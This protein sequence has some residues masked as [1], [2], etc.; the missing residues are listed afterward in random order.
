MINEISGYYSCSIN[1]SYISTWYT[2]FKSKSRYDNT[3]RLFP[4]ATPEISTSILPNQEPTGW[5]DF[6]QS[7]NKNEIPAN[8]AD[9]SHH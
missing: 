2:S 8:L 7:I 9:N 1:P 6:Q 5:E 3:P 4:E